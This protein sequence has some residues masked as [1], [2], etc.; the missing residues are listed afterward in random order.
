MYEN[1]TVE[2]IKSDILTRISTDVDTREGSFTNDMISAAS[3]EIWKLYQSLDALIPMVFINE[4]SG[5]YIDKRCAEYGIERKAGAKAL[6]VLSFTGTDG[7]IIPQGKAFL[8][9]DGLEF[10]TEEKVTIS[11]GVATAT[12]TAAEIGSKYNVEA[13]TITGQYTNI[14]GLVSI[15]NILAIG[16]T[17]PES[18]AA[19]V[20]RLY[21]FLQKPSTSGNA[22]NYKQWAMEVPGVGD[23]KVFPLWNG[24][25][26]VK[27]VIAD[28]NKQ[29]VSS[30]LITD[31]HS[32]IEAVRPIGPTITVTSGVAKIV[33]IKARLSLAPGWT[34]Q[35]VT[36]MF[37][38]ALREQFKNIAFSASYISH[39]KIGTLLLGIDG[40]LDY[41][42]LQ[43]N[44]SN[45]NIALADEE[46]PVI[47]SVDLEV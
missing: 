15:T 11:G 17:E 22:H 32:Y 16:G 24:P 37:E 30:Q 43:L 34:L 44:D 4:T 3:Y 36:E 40:V 12:A 28:N 41:S 31:V 14:S 8:T 38:R 33:K 26:T 45:S 18:D 20:K 35:A 46:I 7:T 27:V 10:I 2:E 25:G 39:A 13:D 21:D 6:T 29:P 42:D 1:L 23:A 47:G 9:A 5:E 19:L